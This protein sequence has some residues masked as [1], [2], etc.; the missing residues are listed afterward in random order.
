MSA[1]S[2]LA[3]VDAEPLD[4]PEVDWS[5][6]SPLLVLTVGALVLLTA[7]ALGVR[8]PPRGTWAV[9]TALLSAG[10]VVATV[11]LWQRV[12][13]DGPFGLVAD[14]LVIDGFSV[15]LTGLIA[16]SIGLAA[17]LADGYL[18]RESLDGPE[19][20]VLMLLSGAGGVMMAMANDLIVLFLGL[21]ILSIALYVLAGYHLRRAESTESA[22]KYF[23][24]GSFS[25]AFLLYG[26]A[27]VYGAT[28]STNLSRIAEFLGQNVLRED[29]LLLAGF[30]L[31]LV[32]LGFKVAA[33][34]FHVW[35]PDVYQ[36]APTPVTAFMASASKAAGFAAML[37]VF[38]STFGLYEDDW[39]PI[40]F[41]VAVLT[42]AVGSI[43]AIVQQDVK[44]M[45]AYSSINHAG[46]VLVGVQAASDRGVSGALFYLL[47]YTFMVVGSFGVVT[48][49]S[50]RGDDDHGIDTY[51]GLATSRPL[52]ALVFT[53]FLLAQAGVP[54]TSGFL[55]KFNV[56]GAAVDAESYA[57][58]ILAMLSAAVSA[59]LYL[60]IVVA[61]YMGS[62]EEGEGAE[63]G[64]DARR[65]AARPRVPAL[66]GIS[67]AVALVVTL[68]VGILPGPAI[69][70]ADDATAE[71]VGSP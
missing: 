36:G 66:A 29:G 39:R 57:L 45:L 28:G 7:T 33:V 44:R 71:Q 4:T 67:L 65:A 9:A 3:Q 20:Y 12:D 59:Y 41:V 24:L 19:L 6:L 18:R 55:A 69:D 31:L 40:L 1:L 13:D 42:L 56:I 60:R 23:V 61:M 11:V 14:A 15:F 64:D 52:L 63:A 26:I 68:L 62:P 58:A 32:G 51:R 5:G 47:A 50:R 8:R 37:R 38:V 16:T 54:F 2:L 22:I 53:V 46:F 43:L 49:V 25:S 27:L 48:L 30:A 21:E 17:L 70:L 35:T 34:P 10:A